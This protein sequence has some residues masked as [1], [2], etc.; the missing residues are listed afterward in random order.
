VVWA[1]DARG[2]YRYRVNF[3]GD[4][5]QHSLDGTNI[6]TALGNFAEYRPPNVYAFGGGENC[7]STPRRG[8]VTV[9][10]GA[11]ASARVSED[12]M[13][14]YTIT[15]VSP[16]I[17]APPVPLALGGDDNCLEVSALPTGASGGALNFYC[18][19]ATAI[20][21]LGVSTN[22]LLKINGCDGSY[23]QIYIP[24][25]S[26]PNGYIAVFWADIATATASG[27]IE[28]QYT[29][30]PGACFT[31]R[32]KTMAYY[33]S[34]LPLGILEATLCPNGT[35]WFDYWASGE[36]PNWFKEAKTTIGAES[37]DGTS[38]VQ[39]STASFG[40]F[41]NLRLMFV[42]DMAASYAGLCAY[43]VT[44]VDSSAFAPPSPPPP[45][46]RDLSTSRMPS[47]A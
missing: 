41:A 38:G 44:N 47:S 37:M 27:S 42:P 31:V 43:S 32:W 5:E 17:C 15:I 34:M 18:G 36:N 40:T 4:I 3:F 2:G 30:A 33:R 29:P 10:C 1:D 28:T 23:E 9:N 46:P 13:C 26:A 8:T 24:N 20:T 11:E 39:V 16:E 21:S 14:V 45:S 35:F 7:G 22:G 19:P 6:V 12:E 25:V